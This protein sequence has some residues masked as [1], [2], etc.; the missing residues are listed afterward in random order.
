MVLELKDPKILGEKHPTYGF[1]VWSETDGDYPVMFNVKSEANLLPG[2]RVTYDS[3]EEKVS[4]KGKEYLRLKGVKFEDSPVKNEDR[5]P[6]TER[7]EP[8]FEKAKEEQTTKDQQITKNMVWKNLLSV[9]DIPSMIPGTDQWEEFWAN[10]ELHTEM[11]TH[12]NMDNLVPKSDIKSKLQKG[13]SDAPDV[14]EAH[15]QE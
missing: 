7:P 8:K 5:K 13:F 1:S 10:V 9:Y 3:A 14:F 2:V 11:L 12:G 4:A 6:F 15:D